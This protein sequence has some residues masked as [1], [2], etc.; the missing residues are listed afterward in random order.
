MY[1]PP[2][3]KE[4]S[5]LFVK[6][7]LRAY[8]ALLGR[9]VKDGQR[10]FFDVHGFPW[11]ARLEAGFED[12]RRE[13]DVVLEERER[14]P[15]FH[16]VEPGQDDISNDRWR[17]LL[18]CVYGRPVEENVSLC[19]RTW[20]LLREIPGMKT[21]LFSILEPGM[22][23]RPHNGPF[24]GVLRYHL[25]LRVPKAGRCEIRVGEEIR[26]WREG[27]SLVFDDTLEHEAWNETDALRAVLFVD[28]VRPLAWPLSV[29]NRA[30]LAV[31]ERLP[32]TR[33]T[34]RNAQGF[35]RAAAG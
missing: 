12:I 24:K 16:E 10:A 26:S 34:Q 17:A 20:Q 2:V 23:I 32:T 28:F 27:E 8:N 19:P 7:G 11:V 18:F 15:G 29:A 30:L 9:V 3:A 1:A 31:A 14:L 25:G 5:R 6:A 33:N 13:L 35:A 21:A 4:R 22:Y